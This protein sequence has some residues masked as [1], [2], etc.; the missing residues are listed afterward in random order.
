M[1]YWQHDETGLIT[2]CGYEPSGRWYEIPTVH[3]DELPKMSDSEYD[4]WY[5]LSC[6]VD[7]VRVG[8]TPFPVTPLPRRVATTQPP[9]IREGA[10]LRQLSWDERRELAAKEA[11]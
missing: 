4:R 7:G 3:E 9:A 5:A 8:P 10:E 1:K 2:T 11:K 6:V